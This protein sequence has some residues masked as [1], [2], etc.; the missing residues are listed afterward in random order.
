MSK[1]SNFQS[2]NDYK[3]KNFFQEQYWKQKEMI[4]FEIFKHF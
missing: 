1:N 2:N 3:K 4:Y